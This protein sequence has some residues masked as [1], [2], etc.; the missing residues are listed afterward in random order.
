ML[1]PYVPHATGTIISTPKG[2]SDEVGFCSSVGSSDDG[3]G[4]R[5]ATGMR[6]CGV[7]VVHA[8]AAGTAS[9]RKRAVR[10]SM[11][12]G[13]TASHLERVSHDTEATD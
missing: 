6:G 11:L 12:R 7:G 8:S 4:P 2:S 9:R 3:G 10:R 13:W 5:A 1:T